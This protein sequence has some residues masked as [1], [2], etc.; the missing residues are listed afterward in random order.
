MTEL[1]VDF[2]TKKH[3]LLHLKQDYFEHDV[4]RFCII[5]SPNY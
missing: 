2:E 1:M 3:N 4:M 5:S